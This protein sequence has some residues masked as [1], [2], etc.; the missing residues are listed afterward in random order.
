MLHGRHIKSLLTETLNPVQTQH[1]IQEA[2]HSS[3]LISSDNG[4]IISYA[5]TEPSSVGY[6]SSINNLK[7]MAL[8]IKDKWSEDERDV[9]EQTTECCYTYDLERETTRIYTY[10]LEDLH[11]CVAQLPRSNLLLLFIANPNYPYGLMV[12]KMKYAIGAFKDM[13]G[14]KLD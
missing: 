2:L 3:L 1:S 10:E 6:N 12:L 9:S 5:N 8:L 14:Y 11:S 13:F 4:A 7:M